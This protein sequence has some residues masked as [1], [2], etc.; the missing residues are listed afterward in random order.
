MEQCAVIKGVRNHEMNYKRAG[1]SSTTDSCVFS[2]N[3]FIPLSK[4]DQIQRID[5][6][7]LIATFDFDKVLRPFRNLKHLVDFAFPRNT[8]FRKV[9][10]AN[11]VAWPPNLQRVSLAG[12]YTGR[13]TFSWE[14]FVRDWPP[15]LRHLVLDGLHNRMVYS[16]ESEVI[17]TLPPHLRS[18]HATCRSGHQPHRNIIAR[19]SSVKILS[20]PANI[21]STNYPADLVRPV[22]EQLE[23]RQAT[24]Y[25]PHHFALSDLLDHV[26]SIPTLRQIRLHSALVEGGS[27]ALEV[28]DQLLKARAQNNNAETENT[29]IKPKDTG[30]VVF[31]S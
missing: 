13:E 2:I 29:T 12:F 16:D 3:G 5:L 15:S 21:A 26:G 27:T 7:L 6:Y 28:A 24:E 31:D 30:V 23:I 4:C 22:L 17:T 19:F 25:G 1:H 20:V 10:E 9:L 8:N 11:K 14:D 18:V